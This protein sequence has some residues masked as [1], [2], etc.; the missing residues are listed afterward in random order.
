MS[1]SLP[2]QPNFEQ[3]KNHAKDLLK[4]QKAGDSAA[5]H[6]IREH[7]PKWAGGSSSRTAAQKFLLS[8]AQLVIAREYGFRSWA[9]LKDSIQRVTQ[10][11]VPF[12]ELADAVGSN[13]I[14][15]AREILAHHPE[16]S[17][18]LNDPV[19]KF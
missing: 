6:R 5:I 19:P 13:D 3:L 9:K 1:K 8:D 4:S 15:Q 2:S 10:P 7:H 11:R 12:E 16:L 17:S 14:A 18:K